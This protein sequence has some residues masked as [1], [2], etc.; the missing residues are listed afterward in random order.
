MSDIFNYLDY[1]H[2]LKDFYREKK[3]AQGS[4]FSYRSFSRAAGLSSP[5][6]L[7]LVMDGK[8]NLG[9]DGIRKFIK[10]LKLNKEGAEHFR[11]LVVFNQ[12]DKTEARSQA[13]Q[14]LARSKRFSEI[15][16]I[17]KDHF[18][19]FASWHHAAIRELVLL[20]DFQEDPNWIAK[21]LRPRITVQAAQESLDLLKRLGFIKQN[22]KGQLVQSERNIA[23]R[24][25]VISLAVANFHR[26]M[27]KKA[28]E[29]IERTAASNRD[30]SSLTVSLSKKGFVEA[31]RR[32]Q[33]FRRELNIL[34]S[35][36]KD[37]DAVYQIN[38][39][40]FNLSEM[41]WSN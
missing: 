38:F 35:E 19:Y 21:K 17:E 27:M 15:R 6:F 34:L 30:I 37:L 7:K 31:K 10:A 20:N 14:K 24:P 32:I 41:P 29:S 12:A 1:R 3:E 4:S 2:Y 11:N 13:Y 18:A 39:Q 23:T 28:T 40:I 8:R 16:E 26:Q 22:E 33:E 5:N 36:E 25:E 9:P